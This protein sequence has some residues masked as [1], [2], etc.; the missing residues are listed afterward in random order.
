MKPRFRLRCRP[1][2]LLSIVV[3]LIL[4]GSGCERRFKES[5]FLLGTIVEITIIA[6][7]GDSQRAM[8]LAFEEIERIDSL[9]NLYNENSEVSRINRSAGKPAVAVSPDTLE[10]VSRSI[11][12]SELTNG[13]FD[14]TVGPLMELWGFRKGQKRIPSDAEVAKT[15]PLVDYRKITVDPRRSTVGLASPGMRIDVGAIA[16]GYAVDKA[17]QA[18]KE[19][20][21]D[22]ALI[23][24]GGE[25][26]ALGSPPGKSAWRIGIRHPRRGNDLIG[27]LELKDRAVSTSGDYE[28]FFE[29]NGKRYCHIM[30]PKIGRPV[31][32]I[33]SATVVADSVTE[34]D[35]LS[36]ALLPSGTKAGMK[37]VESL[38]G[39]DCMIVTGEKEE[40]MKILMSGGMKENLSED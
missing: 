35:A 28:N 24:A 27:I 25:I 39:V 3:S 40:D 11:K 36:T 16:V 10:V 8:R 9:M 1:C 4:L 17:I 32:G 26:Y 20:G 38:K 7:K 14:I 22:K 34:A 21:I 15:L 12:F 13:A 5:K 2:L 37:L 30:N 23:N 31:E 6:S 18:L 19:A 33:M 29:A